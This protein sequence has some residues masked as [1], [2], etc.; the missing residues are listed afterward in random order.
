[1]QNN[2]EVPWGFGDIL[3]EGRDFTG[4]GAKQFC[5]LQILIA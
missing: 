1:M 5:E 4:A 3:G 2:R